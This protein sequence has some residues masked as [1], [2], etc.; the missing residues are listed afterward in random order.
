MSCSSR[1]AAAQE[2]DLRQRQPMAVRRDGAKAFFVGL[3]QQP[4]QV[5][6]HI[7]L[8]HRKV[9]FLDQSTQIGAYLGAKFA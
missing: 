5:V 3:E 7:L 8:G 9:R 6:P 4:I 1:V 2:I